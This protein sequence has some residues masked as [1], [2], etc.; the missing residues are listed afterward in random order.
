[1]DDQRNLAKSWILT[2][3]YSRSAPCMHGSVN[4]FN[5][6]SKVREDNWI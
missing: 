4:T 3:R 1:M 2:Q 5:H 6:G